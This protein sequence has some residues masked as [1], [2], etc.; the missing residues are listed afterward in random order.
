MRQG[1]IPRPTAADQVQDM[2]EQE[3]RQRLTEMLEEAK[4]PPG[5]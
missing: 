2:S 1:V 3:I 4:V 5:L